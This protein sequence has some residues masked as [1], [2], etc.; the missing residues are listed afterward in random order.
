MQSPGFRRCGFILLLSSAATFSRASEF[1]LILRPGGSSW[2]IEDAEK[3]SVNKKE[4]LLTGPLNSREVRADEYKK[5]TKVQLARAGVLRRHAA[6]YLARRDG[7]NW[8]PTAPEG[9]SV[10]SASSYAALWDS[11]QIT[12]QRDRSAKSA[13]PI[14]AADLFAIVPGGDRNEAVADFL[15]D[16]S[17]FRGLGEKSAEAAFDERMSLLEDVGPKLTGAPDARVRGMLLTEMRTADQKLSSG[18]AHYSDLEHGLKFVR[19]SQKTFPNDPDQTKARAA[20]SDRKVWLDRRVAILKALGAGELWDAFLDKYAEFE[21]WD[22]SFPELRQ[23][24]ERAFNESKAEHLAKGNRLLEQRQYDPALR[25]LKI[26]QLRSPGDKEIASTIE[27]ATIKRDTTK[28][29]PPPPD[30]NSP[31]QIQIM[32]HIRS[33]EQFIDAKQPNLKAAEDEILQAEQLNKDS[34]NIL[35]ARARLL[36]ATGQWLKALDMVGQYERR[37]GKEEWTPAELLRGEIV[38]ELRTA[39]DSTKA[40]ILKAEAEGD[41]PAAFAAAKAGLALDVN[42]PDFLLHG[43]L[44]GAIVRKNSD[45]EQLLNKY[46]RL[47]QGPGSDTAQHDKVYNALRQVKETVAEPADGVPNWF[48]GYKLPTGVFYCPI[49]LAFNARVSE[50]RGSR[51][52]T[53]TFTWSGD[54]LQKI[55]V[56]S[57]QP[58]ERPFSAYFDYYSNPRSVR[59][60]SSEPLTATAAAQGAPRLTPEGPVGA[61]IGV[62]TAML[63]LPQVDPLMVEKL[64]GKHTAAIVAGNPYFHPFVWDGIYLFMVEYDNQGRVTSAR[65][66]PTGSAAR[67]D[68][69]NFEF[70]WDGLNLKEINERGSGSYSRTM[71]YRDGRLISEAISYGNAHPK[72]EYK[73]KGDHLVEADCSNDPSLDGRSRHVQFR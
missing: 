60:V 45:A 17:N 2:E 69:H 12:M 49:S 30:P 15:L 1:V 10:K 27:L 63:N 20:L 53:T 42:D 64:T 19:V 59:R 43:G 72:I 44:V 9:L 56:D 73:Y 6:G 68:L 14:R 8:Q 62:Y 33:A 65:Q 58:G 7:N 23:L 5:L 28:P 50:V 13:T 36:R 3:I 47:S 71:T 57:D 70:R 35:L 38:P 48:S 52:Q 37:V 29:P 32:R 26:A 41:Y 22:N 66:V 21:R 46:L 61:G 25:E 51:K 67:A 39:K 31:E 11:A 40:A 16:E 4:G 34:P 55:T 18:I 24:R 54:L